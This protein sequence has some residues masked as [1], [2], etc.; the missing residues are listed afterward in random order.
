MSFWCRFGSVLEGIFG[1]FFALVH[2]RIALG[3]LSSSK[4]CFSRSPAARGVFFSIFPSKMTQDRPKS[5]PRGNFF[6]LKFRPRFWIVF[7]SIL[8]P[9]MPPF[10][11][12]FRSQ[13]RPQKRSKIEL[14]K[15][16]LQDRPET[17]QD[18]PSL[19]F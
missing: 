16:S 11:H 1:P 15:K 3:H 12:P 6:A 9:K 5:L 13:N 8:A 19:H 17:A 10:W 18:R 7:C 14:P 4:K 2:S